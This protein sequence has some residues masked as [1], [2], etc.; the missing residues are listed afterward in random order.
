LR[1]EL[2]PVESEFLNWFARQ[3]VNDI[4]PR[5]LSDDPTCR[6]VPDSV[7][8]Q[9]TTDERAFGDKGEASDGG[10]Q[11]PDL[12]GQ[13]DFHPLDAQGAQPQQ[14]VMS[15]L[16]VL[17][18]KNSSR[19]SHVPCPL[20]LI[21]QPSTFALLGDVEFTESGVINSAHNRC[22]VL[23]QTDRYCPNRHASNE[24]CRPVYWVND[25]SD[26][27]LNARLNFLTQHF[28][29]RESFW[30]VLSAKSPQQP[31]L[32]RSQR[33]GPTSPK[34]SLVRNTKEPTLLLCG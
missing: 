9:D 34:E 7:V 30:R 12:A 17:S 20:S 3:Q 18:D 2:L 6:Y 28:N 33:T 26:I 14:V 16:V 13:I 27:L 4:R 25:P 15:D 22:S 8:C 32:L 19:L 5:F 24:I 31:C 10:A 29:A 1:W 21:T 11:T 23:N